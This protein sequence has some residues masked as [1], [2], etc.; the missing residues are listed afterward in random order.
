MSSCACSSSRRVRAAAVA[1]T[2][3]VL[4]AGLVGFADTAQASGSGSRGSGQPPHDRPVV[5]AKSGKGGEQR[6][7]ASRGGGVDETHHRAALAAAAQARVEAVRTY[8][9]LYRERGQRAGFTTEDRFSAALGKIAERGREGVIIVPL[10]NTERPV[11][12]FVHVTRVGD[13]WTWR[14]LAHDESESA[15]LD[16]RQLADFDAHSSGASWSMN[17]AKGMDL[18]SNLLDEL[19]ALYRS[20]PPR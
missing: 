18:K 2:G 14:V 19:L 17:V 20:G 8:W 7:E 12:T 13:A 5:T 16:A 4:V 11:P 9:S 10:T 15:P 3:S 1:V 6:I